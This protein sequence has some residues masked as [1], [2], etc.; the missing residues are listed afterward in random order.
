MYGIAR[1]HDLGQPQ[2]TPPP[3]AHLFFQ[4]SQVMKPRFQIVELRTS[5][6]SEPD[7]HRKLSH[8]FITETNC[9]H[10]WHLWINATNYPKKLKKYSNL[11]FYGIVCLF[12]LDS[13]EWRGGVEC[14]AR[15]RS[16]ELQAPTESRTAF[17]SQPVHAGFRFPVSTQDCMA[18][19]CTWTLA[20]TSVLRHKSTREIL[21]FLCSI[22][23]S[24]YYSPELTL[25]SAAAA[26]SNCAVI[27]LMW[28]CSDW[29]WE[30]RQGSLAGNSPIQNLLLNRSN[31]YHRMDMELF[32][33]QHSVLQHLLPLLRSAS[34][35][36]L[37]CGHRGPQNQTH[38]TVCFF[39]H[40]HVMTITYYHHLLDIFWAVVARPLLSVSVGLR[41]EFV[42][43]V[44]QQLSFLLSD[45][46]TIQISRK[47]L[48]KG[49]SDV[50][51]EMHLN[52]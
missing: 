22:T 21:L 45:G 19:P 18:C 15:K 26:P 33:F 52:L 37:L 36:P 42:C 29:E 50:E 40:R 25:L 16:L 24:P 5:P 47:P 28:T 34:S 44:W 31:A 11:D 32:P 46:S 41:N 1:Y 27:V 13:S 17:R 49:S 23:Y 7:A 39:V 30:K 12:G 48:L 6:Q 38:L 43:G 3:H 9:L 2:W 10:A 8:G 35:C 51:Q 14:L 20:Y 4:S